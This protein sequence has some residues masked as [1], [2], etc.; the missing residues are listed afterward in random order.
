MRIN[1][2]VYSGD[3]EVGNKISPLLFGK[4]LFS[5]QIEN[6][7]NKNYGED[8][9]VILIRYFI[10]GKIVKFPV[11]KRQ[12][13]N[14]NKIDK[15]IICNFNI[16][17]NSLSSLNDDDIRGFIKTSTIKGINII[18]TKLSSKLFDFNFEALVNDL[19]N[20]FSNFKSCTK[21]DIFLN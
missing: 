3:A 13:S 10:D 8:L 5:D 19:D 9:K 11:S 4:K 7:I 6:S 12:L 20:F 2:Y 18:K 15:S 14:Y 1:Y 17:G 21:D 16:N